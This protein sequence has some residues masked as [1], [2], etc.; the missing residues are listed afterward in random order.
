MENKPVLGKIEPVPRKLRRRRPGDA[1]LAINRLLGELDGSGV[2]R[3]L[4]RQFLYEP[5]LVTAL[6][7]WID[8]WRHGRFPGEAAE[9][10]WMLERDVARIDDLLGRQLDAVIHNPRFQQ[11]EASWR[12]LLDLVGRIPDGANVKV[13]VFPASWVEVARDL[14]RAI[15]FDQSVLFRK[16]YSDEFDMPGGEPFSVLVGDYEV[17]HRPNREH[18]T[19]FDL[20]LM[21][22]L[23]DVGGIPAEG[24]KLVV[25]ASVKK[26]L[27]VR[28]FDDQGK[29]VVDIDEIR[30]TGK[31][32][33]QKISG[34]KC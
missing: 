10:I 15:E 28:I 21:S 20:R 23:D 12:G 16:V 26:L 27:N 1:L 22:S 25:V 13:R 11:L 34:S 3:S 6:A 7:L 19:E 18:A 32:R 14:E 29:R 30:I 2:P 5:D 8:Q 4:L 33:E 24:K 31:V 9:L 17:H